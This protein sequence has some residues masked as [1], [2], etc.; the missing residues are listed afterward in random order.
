MKQ[1]STSILGCGWLGYPLAKHLVSLGFSVKGSTTTP[2]KLKILREHRIVPF[3][4][5]GEHYITGNPQEFFNSNILFLNIP[6][7]RDLKDP[8]FF[9]EQIQSV[10]E[11]VCKSSIEFVI[12]ASSTSI[13]PQSLECACEDASF[14]PDNP[15]SQVLYETEQLLLN[16]R[17]FQTTIIRFAGLCGET[18]VPR[19]LTSVLN[20]IHL[21]DCVEIV[22]KIIRQNIRGEI[23]NACADVHLPVFKE[24]KEGARKVVSNEK[25]KSY[26]GYQFKYP[27][28]LD[29]P[30]F[31]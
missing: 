18:R 21:D 20:L 16:N 22:T 26:L 23:F 28:P 3:L 2:E 17:F 8:H 4:I 29:F 19:T 5:N 14:V 1:P 31:I 15:R 30:E 27:N 11:H 13:Y 10:I 6:F 9:K 24:A 12:F 7:R 25:L